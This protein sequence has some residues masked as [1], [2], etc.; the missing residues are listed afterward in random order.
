[1]SG[2]GG[3]SGNS[4]S[5][6]TQTNIPDWLQDPAKRNVAQG[7]ALTGPD[8]Q[9]Q[10]YGGQRVAGFSP[11][12]NAAFQGVAGMQTPGQYGQAQGSLSNAQDIAN[13]AALQGSMYQ[14]GQFQGATYDPSMQ[15]AT[16]Y[17]ASQM[18]AAGPVGTGTFDQ[19]AAQQYMSPYQ[20]SVTDV[21]KEK[22]ALEGQQMM[23]RL[24]GVAAQNGAFGGARFGL[25]QAQGIRDIGANLSNLQVQGSQSAFDRAQQQY[26]A[27]Q[28][29]GLQAGMFNAGNTQAAN[30][31][32]M[33]ALNQAG[34]FGAGAANTAAGANQAAMNAA[35]QFGGQNWMT[36][37]QAAEQSRQ[38]GN[39]A[40]LRGA[41]LAARTGLSAA[42]QY[43][44]L[45]TAQQ[46]SDLERLNALSAAGA[47][48]Q[49]NAQQNADV[50]YGNF[51]D[52]RDFQKNNLSWMNNLI[53]GT[54][55]GSTQTQSA[56]QVST[57][58]QIGGLGLG[59][60]GAYRQFSG[61]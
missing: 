9:Y 14:P 21:A 23:N 34:M 35:Q 52:S 54:P 36:A 46:A 31:A 30:L 11:Y 56:P 50:G 37:Q 24:G 22:A 8:A 42:S 43:Q 47:L 40:A 3:G 27:D 38:F 39:D 51:V 17:N 33:G 25:E 57:A 13:S 1:M 2:S 41:D 61:G 7:E 26:N 19:N 10:Q 6:V 12:Q 53:R 15:G 48:Q 45:G 28:S 29:R 59:A 55:A 16:G 20:Q 58:A 32:N 4:T 60:L 44:N 18:Q 5:T 49:Q